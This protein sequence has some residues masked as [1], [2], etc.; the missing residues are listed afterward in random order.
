[1]LRNPERNK[2]MG[3]TAQRLVEESRGATERAVTAI[4]GELDKVHAAD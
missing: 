2:K 1:L 3:E 4:R